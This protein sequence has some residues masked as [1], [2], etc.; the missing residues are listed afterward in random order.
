MRYSF[1]SEG[2]S[3]YICMHAET[4]M[5][6]RL[7]G[8][9]FAEQCLQ[10]RILFRETTEETVDQEF[11]EEKLFLDLSY[12][13]VM[14]EGVAELLINAMQKWISCNC[15]VYL[16]KTEPELY[17]GLKPELECLRSAGHLTVTKD[18]YNKI[19]IRFTGTPPEERNENWIKNTVHHIHKENIMLLREETPSGKK[20]PVVRLLAQEE[21]CL[22]YFFYRMAVR[23][24]ESGMCHATYEE[25]RNYFL[26]PLCGDAVPVA[27]ELAAFL[28]ME[29]ADE[30]KNLQAEA[31][32]IIVRDV[33]RMTC[34]QNAITRRARAAGAEIV[35]AVCLLD[36]Y[37]GIG[38]KE[39]RVSFYTIDMDKGSAF[40]EMWLKNDL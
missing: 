6:L 34:Q 18:A 40:K 19:I 14:E 26:L 33:I 15:E 12:L 16:I 13:Q 35:G 3:H 4:A 32:Y 31:K 39:K 1:I 28:H 11:S 24:V 25:N 22:I 38:A 27:M 17:E 2:E 21:N 20:I 30:E 9:G 5:Y 23:M 7:K 36:I 29:V 37:T 8:E 10:N